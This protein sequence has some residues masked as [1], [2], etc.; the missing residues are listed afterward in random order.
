[1]FTTDSADLML[2]DLLGGWSVTALSPD[3]I[4]AVHLLILIIR[5]YFLILL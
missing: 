5:R 3:I 4:F 1:M 2:G